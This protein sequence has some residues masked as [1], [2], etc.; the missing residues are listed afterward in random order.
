MFEKILENILK[1]YL[2]NFINGID[3]NN[4]SLGVFSG[5]I[6]IENVSI[7]PEILKMLEF[8]IKLINSNIG[9]LSITVPWS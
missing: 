1:S 5:N 3:S 9:K 2:G 6:I 8:P 4:L 7:K